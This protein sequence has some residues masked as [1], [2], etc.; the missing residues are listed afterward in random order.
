LT[1]LQW[2]RIGV[3]LNFRTLNSKYAPFNWWTP[4]PLT[5]ILNFFGN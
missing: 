3:N 1:Q 4:G 2:K 5:Y